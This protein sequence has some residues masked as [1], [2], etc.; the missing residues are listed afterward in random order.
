M[1]FSKG[2]G[3]SQFVQEV[4]HLMA[5]LVSAKGKRRRRKRV[6]NLAHCKHQLA[7]LLL[8]QNIPKLTSTKKGWVY[9][10]WNLLPSPTIQTLPHS[11]KISIKAWLCLGRV[12]TESV[13]LNEEASMLDWTIWQVVFW[14]VLPRLTWSPFC[15][16]KVGYNEDSSWVLV[17]WSELLLLNLTHEA[18]GLV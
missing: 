11:R 4:E 9:Q 15:S 13:G 6:F 2:F 16:Q 10:L 14:C 1:G 5:M 17:K 8:D 18:F 7:H 12:L 3:L